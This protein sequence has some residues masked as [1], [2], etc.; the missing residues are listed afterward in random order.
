MIFQL[1]DIRKRKMKQKKKAAK[2][3]GESEENKAEEDP[4]PVYDKRGNYVRS[5]QSSSM[6]ESWT[7]EHGGYHEKTIVTTE[8]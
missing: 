7:D 3:A 5:Q 1:T 4:E 2:K 8:V 6:V